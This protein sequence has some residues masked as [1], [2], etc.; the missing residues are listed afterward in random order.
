MMEYLP[1]P[2]GHSW[3]LENGAIIEVLDL[4]WSPSGRLFGNV[5]V[6]IDGTVLGSG[7]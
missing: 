1:I 5:R 2:R 3:T 7:Y 6:A 4:K